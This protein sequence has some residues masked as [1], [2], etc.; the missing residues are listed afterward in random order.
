MRYALK[1]LPILSNKRICKESKLVEFF[2]QKFR[3]K[4]IWRCKEVQGE[5]GSLRSSA[6]LT[7]SF[8]RKSKG[9]NHKYSFA[10]SPVH[11]LCSFRFWLK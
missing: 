7:S 9:A 11:I 3:L 5:T 8:S 10:F 2:S 4:E 6:F 1:E